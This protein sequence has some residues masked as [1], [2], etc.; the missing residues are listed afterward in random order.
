MNT[1]NPSTAPVQTRRRLIQAG[2]TL[3]VWSAPVLTAV[4]LP[5]HAQTSMCMTIR[6]V[7]GPL[8]GHASGAAT[9]QS[10]CEAEASSQ[11]ALLC[12]VRETPTATGTDC[13]CDF[14]VP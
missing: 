10:A 13:Q 7:G 12:A 6:T 3:P 5:A 1:E 14:E 9:C 4:V 8:S 11:G 2:V